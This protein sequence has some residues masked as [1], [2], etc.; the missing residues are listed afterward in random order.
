MIKKIIALICCFLVS[1]AFAQFEPGTISAGALFGYNSYGDSEDGDRLDI[2][3]VGD[4]QMELLVVKPTLSYFI[5]GNISVD[6]LMNVMRIKS[7]D[8]DPQTIK[9]L[10][11]GATMYFMQNFYAGG[12]IALQSS[13]S[14]SDDW[15]YSS[16]AQYIG[17]QG[18][19]LHKVAENVYLDVA[20]NYLMGI[21]DTKY[22]IEDYGETYDSEDKNTANAY[23]INIG[24]KAFFKQ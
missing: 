12:S 18:G 3:S 7:G 15:S 11:G 19:F 23:G 24:I 22:E 9:L 20:V 8:G 17:I 4:S 16:S 1:F 2:M 13:N 14:E 6:G 5:T 21:G 10:G